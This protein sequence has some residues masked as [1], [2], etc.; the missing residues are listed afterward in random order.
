[1]KKILTIVILFISIFANAQS[2][3][4]IVYTYT[5]QQNFL[6]D[7]AHKLTESI[8]DEHMQ[9]LQLSDN[10]PKNTKMAVLRYERNYTR[11]MKALIQVSHEEINALKKYKN[12][13]PGAYTQFIN[14]GIAKETERIRIN[15]EEIDYLTN[16]YNIDINEYVRLYGNSYSKIF[17][18]DDA[19]LTNLGVPKL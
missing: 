14:E 16:R 4:Q 10:P 2:L 15:N 17:A 8:D 1:M 12:A 6:M 11:V 7:I 18:E 5:T 3:E 19:T 13:H 9:L